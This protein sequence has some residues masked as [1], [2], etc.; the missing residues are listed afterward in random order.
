M[1]GIPFRRESR[2]CPTLTGGILGLRSREI[3]EAMSA[4]F[5]LKRATFRDQPAWCLQQ[6]SGPDILP[7][8]VHHRK[9]RHAITYAQQVAGLVRCVVHL[10]GRHRVVRAVKGF[11]ESA[12]CHHEARS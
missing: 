4:H 11:S 1:N 10:E 7:F 9:V 6:S 2:E 8:A 3:E 12:P 5:T